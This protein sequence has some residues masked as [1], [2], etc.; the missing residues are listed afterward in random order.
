MAIF[1]C[2]LRGGAE[3]CPA[4]IAIATV[5]LAT[6]TLS[7]QAK[8]PYPVDWKKAGAEALDHFT[9]LLRIDTSNP[10][11]NESKAALYLKQVLEKEGISC[12]LFALEPDR[13]NLVARLKGSGAK[14]ALLVMGHTD[15]VGVQK[16]KWTFDPF[17]PTRKD[18]YI[19]ARGAVDDKDN[20]TAGLMLMLLLKRSNVKLDRDVIFLAE[21]GEEGTTRVGID[22]MVD[23]HWPEI[24]AEY[25][26]TEGGATAARDGKVRYVGISATEKVP[27]PVHLIAHGP[28]GHGSRPTP[29]NAVLRLA[30]AVAK[31][32]TWQA[33]MRLNETTRAYFERLATISSPEEARRYNHIGDPAAAPAI[34][35]YFAQHELSH[36]AI[37]R[38]TIVPTIIKA[39]FRTNVIPSEADATLDVRALPDE[40]LDRFYGE[41]RRVI[42]D[43]NVEVVPSKLR[44]RPVSRP[45]R[46]DTDMFRALEHAQRRM[47]PGAI[48]LP[49]MSGGA[50]DNAQLRAKGV[51]A[52]GFGPIVDERD[53]HGAHSDDER[54]AE[55]SIPKLVE[56]LWYAALEVAAAH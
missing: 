10:P 13:A 25:A 20:L 44:G 15:V 14:K 41:L 55:T 5:L 2:S 42:G 8:D 37:L 53:S 16:E 38:T 7:A 19:Y 6:A 29:D 39:G 21:A 28:A 56:Y 40:N 18:G 24:E 9:D 17:T 30:S 51:E 46:L 35:K 43:P 36:D 27:R 47:F 22:Y 11:G 12:R 31:V 33:P 45:S 23:Q 32:G 4:Q 54:V 3:R 49:Q 34:E 52:Y 48:T 26:L 1:R 50:T